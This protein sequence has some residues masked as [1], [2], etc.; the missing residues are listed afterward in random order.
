MVHFL[1][2]CALIGS[3]NLLKGVDT[4]GGVRQ[5]AGY[6]GVFG[7]RPSYGAVSHL[8]VIPVSTSFDTVGMN[9]LIIPSYTHKVYMYF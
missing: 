5:P 9:S 3:N 6:C 2:V 1:R 4:V 8:G 7:F